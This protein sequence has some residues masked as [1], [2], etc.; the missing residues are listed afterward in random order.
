MT[1]TLFVPPFDV[2]PKPRELTGAPSARLL[3]V[4]KVDP[5]LLAEETGEYIDPIDGEEVPM[6]KRQD[7]VTPEPGVQEGEI[8]EP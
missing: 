3:A 7:W 1:V 5:I 4:R 6:G 8:S 2:P